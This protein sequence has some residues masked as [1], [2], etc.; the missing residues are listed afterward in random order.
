MFKVKAT[1]VGFLG[2]QKRYPCHHQYALGDTFSFDGAVF[3]GSI[4]P[5]LAIEAVPKM[6]EVHAAGPRYRGY[7]F[8]YPFLYSP[9]SVEDSTYKRYDGLGF[10]NVFDNYTVTKFDMANLT[11]SGAVAWPPPPEPIKHMDV[12][13]ICPDYRTSVVVKIEAYDVS[14]AGRNIPFFRREMC[15][16]D[17]V[18]KKPGV[19][20]SRVLNEFS[21]E[22]IEEIYPALSSA[23]VASLLEELALMGYLVIDN[24]AV[25]ATVKAEKKLSDFKKSLSSEEKRSL[26]LG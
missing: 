17:K 7:L 13:V 14:D 6:M 11:T 9:H 26:R 10:R 5:S 18:L 22:E 25:K 2:D 23:M 16:L 8:H 21:P 20:A 19:A 12:R 1:V 24:D 15:I 4:C 3:T